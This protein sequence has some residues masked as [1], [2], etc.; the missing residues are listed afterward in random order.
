MASQD[1]RR[2]DDMGDGARIDRLVHRVQSYA[3]IASSRASASTSNDTSNDES[4]SSFPCAAILATAI[5]VA[6]LRGAGLEL[7]VVAGL[8]LLPPLFVTIPALASNGGL[9][10]GTDRKSVV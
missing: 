6:L 8:V 3:F 4:A 1:L 10:R 7:A 2:L 9:N 5:L